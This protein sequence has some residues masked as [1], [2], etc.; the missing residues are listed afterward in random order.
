MLEFAKEASIMR[1]Y[2]D[3]FA[4]IAGAELRV[5]P[6]NQKAAEQ[7]VSQGESVLV[8][9]VGAFCTADTLQDTRALST[10]VEKNAM[11]YFAAKAGNGTPL[12]EQDCR[13]MRKNYLE[14]Y[15]KLSQVK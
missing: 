8:K 13:K 5:L 1:P 9:T 2:L 7:A 15:S 4:Q 14:Y 3:D 12:D 11:A 6:R 10:I